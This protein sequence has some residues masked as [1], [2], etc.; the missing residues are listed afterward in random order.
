[1][2]TKKIMKLLNYKKADSKNLV[3]IKDSIMFHKKC[4]LM[5]SIA[6]P[7]MLLKLNMDASDN[8]P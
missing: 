3:K 7:K 8:S 4:T 2:F 1:M 5:I 6:F